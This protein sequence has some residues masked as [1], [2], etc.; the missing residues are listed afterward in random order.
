[1]PE[2][3][4]RRPAMATL[5][6]FL[7]IGE[8]VEH[9][10]AVGEAALDEVQR[11]EQLISLFD[12]GSELARFNREATGGPVSV[13]YELN[14]ILERCQQHHKLTARWFDPC[15][16]GPVPFAQAV[17]WESLGTHHVRLTHP[18]S[19]VDLGGYG[20]GYALDSARQLLARFSV[21]EYLLHGG[22]SSV[23]A[24]GERSWPIHLRAPAH[25]RVLGR[26]AL[27]NE[28]LSCSASGGVGTAV[29][30]ESGEMAEVWSTALIAAGWEQWSSLNTA[31]ILAAAW[32]ESEIEWLLERRK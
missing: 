18:D 20:K 3:V 31:G 17:Q 11:I 9:L 16:G 22:T 32:L 8:D 28:A 7:L 26:I 27:R 14:E 29:V 21:N 30:A 25:E 23:V 12:P 1:M 13:A 10:E 19:R 2:V 15:H 5:F 24:G 6:E 4:C